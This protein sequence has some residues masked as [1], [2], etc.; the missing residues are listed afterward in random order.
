[1]KQLQN[2][3]VN[4]MCT[5]CVIKARGKHIPVSFSCAWAKMRFYS[6][7][8]RVLAGSLDLP[9]VSVIHAEHPLHILL[10]VHHHLVADGDMNWGRLL[11][12]VR[13][14]EECS[15]TREEWDALFMF[16]KQTHPNLFPNVFFLLGRILV[17]TLSHL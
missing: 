12:F 13:Y 11:Y 16:L 7:L 17:F 5:N 10:S 9:P 2:L 8:V 15:L 14:A 6:A 3:F 1:M 4:D